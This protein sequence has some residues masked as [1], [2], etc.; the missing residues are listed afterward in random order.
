MANGGTLFLDEIGELDLPLQAKLLRVVEDMKV[1][2]LGGDQSVTINFRLM[3]ATN[4]NLEDEVKAGRF[5]EDLYYR[6]NVITLHLPPLRE[7]KGDIPLLV[8]YFVDKFN[9]KLNQHIE[10]IDKRVI[11]AV[12]NYAFPGNIRELENL[13]ERLVAMAEDSIIKFEDLPEKYRIAN[14]MADAKEKLIV[15]MGISIK[16]IER[17]AIL[18]TLEYFDGNKKRTAESLGISER[19]LHYKLKSYEAE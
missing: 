8:R 4:K 6:L 9:L 11:Q 12:E 18:R 5:R 19:N 16:A 14:T 3:A 17:E 10:K 15:P 2:P 1:T 7:R 13:I